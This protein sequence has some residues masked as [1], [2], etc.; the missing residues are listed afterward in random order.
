[1]RNWNHMIGHRP[2]ARL[3][4]RL[5]TIGVV[6][7]M[8]VFSALPHIANPYAFL[9]T[10]YSYQIVGKT[11]GVVVAIT[12]PYI[13]LVLGIAL[14]FEAKLR[15]LAFL[16][17]IPLFALFL[18]AQISAVA[19]GLNIACGCFGSSTS[20][21]GKSTLAVAMIGLMTCVLGAFL[22]RPGATDANSRP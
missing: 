20:T 8:L 16:V 9:S 14:M 19:R 1:M 12:L 4:G 13:E 5:L 7:G 21:V 6:S 11:L 10:V 15:R 3:A 18:G 2:V 17:C 22:Y